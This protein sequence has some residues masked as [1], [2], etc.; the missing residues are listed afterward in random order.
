MPIGKPSAEISPPFSLVTDTL[1][2]S[3]QPQT[4]SFPMRPSLF[5]RA[6]SVLTMLH[7]IGHT[8]GGV[9]S[10]DAAPTPEEAAVITAMKSHRFEVM[11]SMRSFWDFFFGY[12]LF[13]SI[14]FLVQAV[15]FWQLASLAKRG[16][17][18][19]R[20]IIA[21]FFLAYI[22][23]AILAW[24]YFFVLPA[25]EEVLIASCLGLAYITAQWG[26]QPTA[27]RKVA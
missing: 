16:L 25:I 22:G 5:L 20:P 21:C 1:P 13:I 3:L 9:F 8:V 14:N 12:G 7:C 2:M 17:K 10:V 26:R 18:E 4:F 24:N 23:F 27:L 6:A 15:L 11:G 19:I